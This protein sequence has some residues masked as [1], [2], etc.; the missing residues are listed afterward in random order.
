MAK[1]LQPPPKFTHPE[2]VISNQ[3]Q[4]ANAEADRAAAERLIEESKRLSDETNKRTDKTQRDVNKKFEQRIDDIKYWQKEVDDKLD[5]IKNETD[6]LKAF[7][8]R[9][10]KAI[11]SCKEPL[12]IA[13]QCL[14]NRQKRK[15]ID[16][17]HDDTEKEL[18]KEV[19]VIQGVLA[20]L[21]RTKEQAVEQQRLNRKAIYNQEKDLTDK[22]SALTIDEHNAEL[23]NNSAGLH[24][25]RG[26][27]KIDANSVTPDDWEDFSNRNILETEKQVQNSISLRSVIDGILQQAANDIRQ[28]KECVDIAFERRIAETRDAKE[29]LEDHLSKVKAQITEMEDNIT[30]LCKTVAD[31]E[32]PLMLANTR[33]ENRA[34]RPNV[35]L[36]R[37]PVQYRLVEEVGEIEESVARLQQRLSQSNEALKG[38]L[39]RQLELEEDIEV[40]ANSLFIDE[41]ECMGM[42]KSISINTY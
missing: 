35:E 15:S 37:D 26:F 13:Q 36:C 3:S 40:K 20:L 22:F 4:Y 25:N 33:L 34:Y 10:D 17:V 2:W 12:H 14:A 29:K 41:T 24:H 39:R 11:E 42:R 6:S 19:E 28:Q 9:L 38:L 5:N 7:S 23:K 32:T 30:R 31:K 18:L 8:N 27:A 16:L 21:E 1:L